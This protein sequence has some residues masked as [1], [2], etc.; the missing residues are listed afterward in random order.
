MYW[1]LGIPAGWVF[2]R[3]GTDSSNGG[4]YR[5][6][7]YSGL[8]IVPSLNVFLFRGFPLLINILKIHL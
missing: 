2:C 1:F 6:S 7:G 8:A 4:S 3:G 5:V